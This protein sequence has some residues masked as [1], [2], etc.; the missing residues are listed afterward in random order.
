MADA[1]SM[2]SGINSRWFVVVFALLIS[3][4]TI[5]LQY[6]QIA[7]VLKWLVLVLFA[8]PITAFVVGADWGQVLRDTLI[9]SMPHSQK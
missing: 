4:A 2:L 6:Q 5:R 3:W 8:Y 7:N 1:A 9:P